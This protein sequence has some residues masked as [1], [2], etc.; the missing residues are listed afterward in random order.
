ML[1]LSCRIINYEATTFTN[2]FGIFSNPTSPTN[3]SAKS[4][5]KP[6]EDEGSLPALIFL[7]AVDPSIP[8]ISNTLPTR[9]IKKM[10]SIITSSEAPEMRCNS[11]DSLKPSKSTG[12]I[13]KDS[14]EDL[15]TS[16]SLG[17]MLQLSDL[18]KQKVNEKQNFVYDAS[19]LTENST[20]SADTGHKV[21]GNDG[22]VF[23][24]PIDRSTRA[25]V[26]SQ[27]FSIT[28]FQNSKPTTKV[29]SSTRAE[30][31]SFEAESS[32]SVSVDTS[33]YDVPRKLLKA[34]TS[35]GAVQKP[36][37]V[38]TPKAPEKMSIMT[39]VPLKVGTE[40][41]IVS[42]PEGIYDVPRS[43]LKQVTETSPSSL[44]GKSETQINKSELKS[45]DSASNE[46]EE[47]YKSSTFHSIEKT[48]E[49]NPGVVN[50]CS[51]DGP[52]ASASSPE[53]STARMALKNL[54][55]DTNFGKGNDQLAKGSNQANS[56]VSGVTSPPSVDEKDNNGSGGEVKTKPRLMPKPKKTSLGTP[57]NGT[58]TAPINGTETAEAEGDGTKEKPTPLPRS[59]K[60]QKR[61]TH[62][63][64]MP[65]NI[66][67][68]L[69]D[70][71]VLIQ[72]KEVENTP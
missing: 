47:S 3:T 63:P 17:K 71:R 54:T 2:T 21:Q 34:Q 13:N 68:E 70:K 50:T 9:K 49:I 46:L 67:Q 59:K 25:E 43:I 1:F 19:K 57:I 33:H 14:A 30:K 60:S 41:K 40:S 45:A 10:E 52:T 16:Q 53:D 6:P 35:S 24:E 5:G 23:M 18:T 20:N 7:S 48:T 32:F 65:G 22:Y 58:E 29:N 15:L 39:G 69:R 8:V 31:S 38:Q 26:H 51:P 28:T 37:D 55:L 27:E 44:E 62:Q 56:N 66:F 61:S 72:N 12:A 11:E 42:K 36:D 64:L 4:Q